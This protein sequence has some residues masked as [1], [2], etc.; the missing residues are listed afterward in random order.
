MID[1]KEQAS[2][3]CNKFVSQGYGPLGDFEHSLFCNTCQ[4]EYCDHDEKA[5]GK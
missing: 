5:K 2:E 4:W 1:T 3:P